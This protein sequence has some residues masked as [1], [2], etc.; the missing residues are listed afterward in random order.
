[1]PKPGS[2]GFSVPGS[3]RGGFKLVKYFR[4]VIS[5]VLIECTQIVVGVFTGPDVRVADVCEGIPTQ[6]E[7]HTA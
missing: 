5:G 6:H 7:R 1:L 2:Q 3:A 4:K